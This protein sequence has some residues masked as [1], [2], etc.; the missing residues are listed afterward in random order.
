MLEYKTIEA[1]AKTLEED[2]NKLTREGWRVVCSVGKRTLI[3]KRKLR[4]LED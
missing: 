1:N 2:L 3:L 4:E